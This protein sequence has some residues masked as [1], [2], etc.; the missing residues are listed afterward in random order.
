[1]DKRWYV[2]W[3]IAF[4]AT[5][6][7]IFFIEVMGK[8]AAS[9]CWIERM[10]MAGTL[11][12]I[13]V[14]IWRRDVHA[15]YYTAPFLFFGI[16]SAFYQQLVHANIIQVPAQ[17]CRDG[18]V[19]TTKFFSFYGFITQATLCLTAFL[20]ILYCLWVYDRKHVNHK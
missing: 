3:I 5:L 17:S 19:C 1:M 20:I 12:I 9:L 4:L 6:A 11:L 16:L 8:P 13:T 15:K 18:F 10:L 14:G 2:A 7:S